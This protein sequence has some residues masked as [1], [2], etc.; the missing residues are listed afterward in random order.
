MAAASRARL[1][2]L[3]G[4]VAAVYPPPASC[5]GWALAIDQQHEK[6]RMAFRRR[7]V[8]VVDAGTDAAAERDIATMIIQ[9]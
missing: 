8:L 4:L 7:T 3:M 9:V 1:A 6:D 5:S 2:S